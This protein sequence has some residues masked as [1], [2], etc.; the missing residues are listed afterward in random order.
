MNCFFCNH[1][2]SIDD[3]YC[4]N[5]E[6]QCW[7]H[8]VVHQINGLYKPQFAKVEFKGELKDNKVVVSYTVAPHPYANTLPEERFL[9]VYKIY[10]YQY[11]STIPGGGMRTGKDQKKILELPYPPITLRPDNYQEKLKTYLL[12]S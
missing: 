4:H 8:N 1:P 9:A 10:E 3:L 12:F 2:I 5:M 11:P 7:Q 6:S